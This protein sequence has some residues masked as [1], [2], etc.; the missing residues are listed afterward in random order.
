M[1]G[2]QAQSTSSHGLHAGMALANWGVRGGRAVPMMGRS[3]ATS[4]TFLQGVV[5]RYVVGLLVVTVLPSFLRWP[6]DFIEGP[7]L[8]GLKASIVGSMVC[9][10]L[11]MMIARQLASYPN[12]SGY[13][14]AI[15]VFL[16]V[17]GV[18]IAIFF[19][20]RIDFSRYQIL[21]SIGLSI[22][23]FALT[24]YLIDRR[25]R[26]RIAVLPYGTTAEIGQN[27]ANVDM[28]RLTHPNEAE[29]SLDAVVADLRANMPPEWERFLA[30][31]AL[32]RVPV[33]HVKQA[34]EW[35]NG[36]VHIEHLSENQFGSLLIPR[37][38]EAIKR[39]TDVLLV[40]LALPLLLPLLLVLAVMVRCDSPG[41]VL[42]VQT[43]MGFRGVPFRM[44]KFRTMHVGRGGPAFTEPEDERVTRM[45]RFLRRYRLD[46]LPQVINILANQMS[47]I[48]PRPETLELSEWYEGEVPFYR[49]RH[50]VRPGITGWAQVNQGQAAGVSEADAKLQ[51]DF[52]YIK[53]FSP[54]LDLLI[55]FKTLRIVV[56]GFGAR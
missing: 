55:A 28:V 37:T 7:M 48:G 44:V 31:C 5:F 4:T 32:Q 9:F 19:F 42:F 12:A 46:E 24:V 47:W 2:T 38:Y 27:L 36:K 16:A 54:W 29:A 17:Y 25:S 40:I 33:Y 49:Y 13:A 11:G 26:L 39:A 35:L 6:L 41:P 53:H 30:E 18:L 34:Y 45:G 56:T 20:G 3:R 23:W 1:A 21:M 14:Y 15:P 43:R 52:F 8:F 22:V 50:I 10:V 51:Y